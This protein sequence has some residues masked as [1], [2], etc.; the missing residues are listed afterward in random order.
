MPGFDPKSPVIQSS[1]TDQTPRFCPKSGFSVEKWAGDEKVG[2]IPKCWEMSKT[3]HLDF[4]HNQTFAA[5][6]LS[7]GFWEFLADLTPFGF[8]WKHGR[9]ILKK[10]ETC[11]QVVPSCFLSKRLPVFELFGWELLE[12]HR[13]SP[14]TT[15]AIGSS[16]RVKLGYWTLGRVW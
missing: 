1:H 10:I 8:L 14:G 6:L 4:A 13:K 16:Q 2:P 12:N 3:S 7:Q 11:F 15:R 5:Q 9:V